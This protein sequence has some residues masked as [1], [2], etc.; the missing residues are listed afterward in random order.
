MTQLKYGSGPDG[1]VAGSAPETA[2]INLIEAAYAVP[3]GRG[4]WED[5]LRDLTHTVGGRAAA[6]V[7]RGRDTVTLPCVRGHG[8]APE[9]VDSYRATWWR[10]DPLVRTGGRLTTQPPLAWSIAEPDAGDFLSRWLVPQG[11]A[12]AMGAVLS[13]EP[14]AGEVLLLV[15]FA[16]DARLPS[17]TALVHL[18]RLLPHVAR[19]VQIDHKVEAARWEEEASRALVDRL[20][21]GIVMVDAGGRVLSMNRR[22]EGFVAGADGLTV[23]RAG[24]LR[25]ATAAGSARLLE[26][27]GATAESGSSDAILVERPSQ[28]RPFSVLVTPL[29]DG[30]SEWGL[31]RAAAMVVIGDPDLE[32]EV[33]PDSLRALYGLTGRQAV[34]VSELCKGGRLED[35]AG[36][37]GISRNT[38]KVQLSRIFERTNTRRQSELIKMILSGPALLHLA[39]GGATDTPPPPAARDERP[40]PPPAPSPP[41]R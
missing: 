29:A 34:L 5:F 17:P 41:P 13:R 33:S 30:G 40:A 26:L 19:A 8:Y 21:V 37:F 6:F 10:A 12:W 22:A 38:A 11:L 23:D 1:G 25:A 4:S 28:R 31:R 36:T 32:A 3:I 24:I 14:D 35:V 7:V 15:H 27:I 39:G 16:P 18:D 2:L 20:P 9:S